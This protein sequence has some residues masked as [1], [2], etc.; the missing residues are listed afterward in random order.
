[1]ATSRDSLNDKLPDA[2]LF[3]ITIFGASFQDLSSLSD[4]FLAVL[5]MRPGL[6]AVCT[7]SSPTTS[8]SS[9]SMLGNSALSYPALADC[10]VSFNYRTF[11]TCPLTFD[12]HCSA[13]N[14]AEILCLSAGVSFVAEPHTEEWFYRLLD[15][16]KEVYYML[17]P[18]LKHHQ[19]ARWGQW[20]GVHLCQSPKCSHGEPLPTR[21]D[22]MDLVR[23]LV[24]L[25][26]DGE[27]LPRVLVV[28]D[29]DF[30][31]ESMQRE[32]W[33]M[34]LTGTPGQ[35]HTTLASH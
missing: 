3:V 9:C 15:P 2:P 6:H 8:T 12:L 35:W 30:E 19:W 11:F 7:P 25:P 28:S 27:A 31:A 29:S 20:I 5:S 18:F 17:N 10:C 33:D 34:Q 21:S 32:V 26:L 22:A 13:E 24:A 23:R 1:M 14:G 16:A 4:L